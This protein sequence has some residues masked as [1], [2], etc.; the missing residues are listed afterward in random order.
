MK[1]IYLLLI[2]A[3]CTTN[4]FAQSNAD[5]AKQ[6]KDMEAAEAKKQAAIPKENIA[7]HV[8]SITT[9]AVTITTL[10][11][12]YK[13]NSFARIDAVTKSQ[14][15]NILASKSSMADMGVMYFISGPKGIASAYYLICNAIIKNA[16]DTLAINDLGILLK[17]DGQYEKAYQCFKY[18]DQLFPSSIF[19]T[20]LG[21]TAAYY[22][23]FISAKKYF[24]DALVLAPTNAGTLEGL[25]TLAAAKGDYQSLMQNLFKR[26]QLS[27]GGAPMAS[28]Q[29]V[30]FLDDAYHNNPELRKQ[31]PFTDH[32]FDTPESAAE[33][34][35]DQPSAS[36]A[37]SE[38]PDYPTFG[39]YF[40]IDPI[41][42]DKKLDQIKQGYKSIKK[43]EQDKEDEVTRLYAS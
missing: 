41:T 31:D 38:T 8:Q 32:T 16:K 39:A 19:K 4:C 26:M 43:D 21:W 29:M 30:N 22:G 17:N 13:K 36:T 3:V 23:D 20:N 27:S 12:T 37:N 6:I 10:A 2:T 15:T 28:S 24:E 40:F 18:A 35:T 7:K 9:S 5:Y 25:C 33:D 14:L 42:I 1:H 34:N 11:T